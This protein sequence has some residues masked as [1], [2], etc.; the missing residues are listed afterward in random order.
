[1]GAK[2]RVV[3][4][5]IRS[6]QST[7]KITRAM[8]LIASSRIVK[9]QQRV[10][11]ARPYAIQL[12][13]AMEDLARNAGSLS[14]PLLEERREPA[15]AGVLVLT[16]QDPAVEVCTADV[17]QWTVDVDLSSP[18]WRATESGRCSGGT[19]SQ[20]FPAPKPAFAS[21]SSQGMGVR[22]PSRPL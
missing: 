5:R 1:M 17:Q 7:K 13:K 8:E 21:R 11:Q 22:Q 12:T 6:V 20:G 4:R 3:R 15:K 18:V 19:G 10:E 16:G 9:A 2:L 14:H